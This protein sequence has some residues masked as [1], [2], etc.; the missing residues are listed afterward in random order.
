MSP[1]QLSWVPVNVKFEIDD[2][3]EEWTHPKNHFDYIH[4]RTLGGSIADWPK[5]MKSSFE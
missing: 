1:I 3:E 4:M 5:L 2:I